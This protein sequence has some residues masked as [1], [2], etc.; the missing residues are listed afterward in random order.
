VESDEVVRPTLKNRYLLNPANEVRFGH[1]VFTHEELKMMY[2]GR[3]TTVK[4]I[5]E[6]LGVN[7]NKLYYLL[8]D[9]GAATG[10]HSELNPFR[11]RVLRFIVAYQRRYKVSPTIPEIASELEMTVGNVHHHLK[12]L[13]EYGYIKRTRKPRSIV[14]IK[15]V[16]HLFPNRKLGREV[17]LYCRGRVVKPCRQR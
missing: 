12:K 3:K 8:R 14:L 9:I 10:R 7:R 15:P 11:L 13:Q 2:L 16:D 5:A 6:S 1:L 4:K 17:S